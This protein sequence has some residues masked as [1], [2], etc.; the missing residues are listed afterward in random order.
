MNETLEEI[1]ERNR[2]TYQAAEWAERHRL[3]AGW[4]ELVDLYPGVTVGDIAGQLQNI[5]EKKGKR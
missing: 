5:S 3:P 1:N 2:R 4:A